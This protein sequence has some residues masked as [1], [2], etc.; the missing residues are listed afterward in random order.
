[1][2]EHV[3]DEL[4]AYSLGVLDGAERERVVAHLA[5]CSVCRELLSEHARVV[6]ALRTQ[7]LQA[8]PDR[9]WRGIAAGLPSRQRRASRRRFAAPLG[10]AAAAAAIVALVAWNVTLQFGGSSSNDVGALAA[11]AEGKVIPLASSTGNQATGRLYVSEDG[12]QGGLAVSGLPL[13]AQGAG[14]H[15]WFVRKDQSRA[16]GGWFRTDER[17]QALVKVT[18]PGPLDQFQGVAIALDAD[19]KVPTPMSGDL[20]AGPLYER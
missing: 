20:L 2:S 8:P 11:S 19:E 16:S 14:Y 18:I 3:I 4:G 12:T 7:P 10:W 13:L 9:V 5:E 17:G 6:E 15:I 1:M